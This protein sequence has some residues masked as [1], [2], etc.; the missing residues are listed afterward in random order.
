MRA[1]DAAQRTKLFE[2]VS[3]SAEARAP[4]LLRPCPPLSAAARA[5]SPPALLSPGPHPSAPLSAA[6]VRAL[7]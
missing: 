3:G 1:M 6:P 5:P 4:P 7:S 2:D